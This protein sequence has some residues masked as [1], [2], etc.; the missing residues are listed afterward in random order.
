M[1]IVLG[2]SVVVMLL[3]YSDL[4]VMNVFFDFILMIV[5]DI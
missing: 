4:V 2:K 1:D 3:I 5:Y